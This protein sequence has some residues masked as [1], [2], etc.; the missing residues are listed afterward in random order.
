[1]PSRL[2]HVHGLGGHRVHSVSVAFDDADCLDEE[3]E[4]AA[5]ILA[6][7]SAVVPASEH[8]HLFARCDGGNAG[9]QGR[10]DRAPVRFGKHARPPVPHAEPVEIVAPALAAAEVFAFPKP[11]LGVP[12]R[13]PARQPAAHTARQK[14]QRR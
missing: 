14:T 11:R 3:F 4:A 13:T 10:H 9:R 12:E 6:E 5:L 1:M 2:V 7:L 8:L